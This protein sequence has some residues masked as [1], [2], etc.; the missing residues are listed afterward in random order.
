M[1]IRDRFERLLTNLETA[2]T[3][4]LQIILIGQEELRTLLDQPE[5]RQLA[6]RITGRYH[7]GAL[8]IA[9]TAGYVKHRMRVAGATAEAFTP[10][11]LRETHRLSSGIPRVINVVC[12]RALLG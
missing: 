9:E 4:L 7:L 2:T 8:S 1:C 6:Q 12:D 10:S 5:L 3:K 11:A